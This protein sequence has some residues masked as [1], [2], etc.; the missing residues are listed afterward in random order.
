MKWKIFLVILF[1]ILPVI[2]PGCGGYSFT[3]GSIG[4]AGSSTISF[5]NYGYGYGGGY[6][7]M[8]PMYYPYQY[9]A[10]ICWHPS[11]GNYHC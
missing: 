10:R 7:M 3:R 8:P 6:Y 9:P 1:L 4:P 5:G 2:L 11:I